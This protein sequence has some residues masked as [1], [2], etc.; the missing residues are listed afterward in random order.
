MLFLHTSHERAV[1]GVV[2]FANAF[3][4]RLPAVLY[5]AATVF[6]ADRVSAEN[7]IALYLVNRILS[8]RIGLALAYKWDAMGDAGDAMRETFL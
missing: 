8:L 6:S 2:S 4:L 5:V 3:V 7:S 1:S